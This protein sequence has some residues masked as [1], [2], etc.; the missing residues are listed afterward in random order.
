M[1]TERILIQGIEFNENRTEGGKGD[2]KSLARNSEKKLCVALINSR[3]GGYGP[4]PDPYGISGSDWEKIF[5]HLGLNL[6]TLRDEAVK[7]YCRQLEKEKE[8]AD[9]E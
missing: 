3:L 9:S 1:K 7:E 6:S 2:I 8:D 4:K 5:S